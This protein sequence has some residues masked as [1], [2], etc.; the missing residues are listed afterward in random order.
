MK[1]IR[2]RCLLLPVIGLLL[3]LF[4][5][6]ATAQ[7]QPGGMDDFHDKLMLLG[8]GPE[9]GSFGPIGNTFC[10]AINAARS[11]S[12]VRC[13]PVLSAGSVFNVY[14][15]ANG[16]LQLGMGQEALLGTAYGSSE[17]KGGAQLRTVAVMHNSPIAVIVRK[18]SGITELKHIR[19]GVVN[20]GNQGAG[21]HANALAVLKAMNLQESD[22]AGVTFLQPLAF[23][24]AFCDGKVDVIFNNLV[25]PSAQYRQLRAC[26]GE[27]LDI[28][29]DIMKQMVQENTWLRPM[30]VP[31]ATYDADQKEVKTLGLRNVLFT[32]AGI[33]EEAIF[34]VATLLASQHK[35]LQA[36][37]SNL[38]SMVLL[39]EDDVSRL[40][41]PLHPGSLR[42]LR[43]G[44]P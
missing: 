5:T 19:R 44:V 28:P 18:A 1:I 13:V 41:A 11:T 9:G 20:I 17:V 37:Q 43:R 27:F 6:C 21:Y 15:V 16:S 29:P 26:G 2:T 33:D 8:T 23:V 10:E 39:E 34:R 32:H 38:S 3:G 7:A 40:A 12:H 22:F 24:Q 42:A 30:T 35:K 4:T 25:H 31:A 14:A 36:S